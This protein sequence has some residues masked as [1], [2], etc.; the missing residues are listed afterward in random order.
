MIFG[1][2]FVILLFILMVIVPT[3][4][5]I[6]VYYLKHR[7]EKVLETIK[8]LNSTIYLLVV[9]WLL[10]PFFATL[11][12]DP[13]SSVIPVFSVVNF[14]IK[15][16]GVAGAYVV[17][18]LIVWELVRLG[19]CVD[20]DFEQIRREFEKSEKYINCRIDDIKKDLELIKQSLLKK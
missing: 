19:R 11:T 12:K 8:S 20:K 3:H 6:I 5:G 17:S 4:L 9:A 14:A 18:L 15:E 1:Y 10:A 16:Y 2:I 7:D 13:I